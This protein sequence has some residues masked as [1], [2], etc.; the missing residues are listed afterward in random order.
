[1]HGHKL[2]ELLKRTS[3]C[4]RWCQA[5]GVDLP[6]VE[7]CF[8]FAPRE[9]S[10]VA[11]ESC[12]RGCVGRD[13]VMYERFVERCVYKERSSRFRF[14]RPRLLSEDESEQLPL[15]DEAAAAR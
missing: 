4:A 3:L 8:C 9:T 12:R 13:A 7:V 1:M 5:V 10:C 11:Y 2:E 14:L 6:L 15:D